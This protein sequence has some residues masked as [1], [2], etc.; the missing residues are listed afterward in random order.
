MP[1]EVVSVDSWQKY[2]FTTLASLILCPFSHLPLDKH[3][4]QNSLKLHL[5]L[6]FCNCNQGRGNHANSY[7]M[8]PIP[9]QPGTQ[10]NILMNGMQGTNQ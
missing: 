10:M 2:I 6:K 5:T 8:P 9:A 7:V 1:Q 3:L 4:W